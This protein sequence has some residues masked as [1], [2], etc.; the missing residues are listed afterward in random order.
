MKK[1]STLE[2]T[3]PA[4]KPRKRVAAYARVS[5]ETERLKH[6]ISAQI[7]H[8]SAFIQKNPEWI[9]AGVYADDA[10]S[11]TGTDKRGEFNMETFQAAQQEFARRYGV[12]IKNGIA[13]KA[14]YFF[15]KNGESGPHPKHRSPQWSDERRRQH[16]EIFRSRET[17]LCR[18]DFSHFIE[19]E[20]CGGHLQASLKHYVDGSTEVGWID[21]ELSSQTFPA[22]IS[23]APN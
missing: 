17:G 4:F 7:S 21:P 23:K 16:A 13:Q 18:Y 3:A 14:S 10:V 6:S 12:E 9:Y 19:C 8:Y 1:I 2:P 15:H 20:N 22:F 5:M 11:G